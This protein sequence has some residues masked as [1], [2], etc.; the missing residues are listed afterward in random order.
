MY[1]LL[2]QTRTVTC[3][4]TVPSS[5]Q[6]ERPT[7]NK[8]ATVLTTIKIWSWVP[9]GRNTKTDWLTISCRADVTSAPCT[10]LCSL[11][12]ALAESCSHDSESSVVSDAYWVTSSMWPPFQGLAV[13]CITPGSD[14]GNDGEWRCS[15]H[16]FT[17]P[18]QKQQKWREVSQTLGQVGLC[19]NACC[20]ILRP[21]NTE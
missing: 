6:G 4:M 19:S 18:F 9:E 21:A 1:I 11:C 14:T 3:Y 12:D 13:R 8:T 7:I 20:S 15:T 2:T 10:Y 17:F 5:R 16:N